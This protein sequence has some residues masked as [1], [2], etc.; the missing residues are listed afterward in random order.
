MKITVEIPDEEIESAVIK[1]LTERISENLY[2]K[3]RG[4]GYAYR[5]DI[6]AIIRE[7]MKENMDD[8]TDRAVKAAAASIENR[9]IKKLMEEI[10]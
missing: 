6:K 8:F 4:A 2:E 7:L 9:G 1:L 10:K 5:K 3:W